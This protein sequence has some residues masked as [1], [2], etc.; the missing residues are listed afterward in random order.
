MPKTSDW[1]APRRKDEVGFKPTRPAVAKTKDISGKV[2]K[3]Q[4]ENILRGTKSGG[5]KRC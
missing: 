3:A 5:G 2:E 1:N 4:R